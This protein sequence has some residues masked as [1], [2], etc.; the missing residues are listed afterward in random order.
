MK[1]KKYASSWNIEA[2][3]MR[4]DDLKQ[5]RREKKEMAVD[6]VDNRLRSR[7]KIGIKEMMGHKRERRMVWGEL[8]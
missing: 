2:V 5:R 3:N 7:G 6:K 1:K 8:K 4:Y